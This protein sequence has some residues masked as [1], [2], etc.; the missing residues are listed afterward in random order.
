MIDENNLCKWAKSMV[1]NRKEQ[2][3]YI[4]QFG[5]E[6]EKALAKTVCDYARKDD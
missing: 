4:M 1:K 6:L 2:I 3:E 5:N